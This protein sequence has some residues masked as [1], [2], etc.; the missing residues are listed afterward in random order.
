[1][2][3]VRVF[4]TIQISIHALRE[5]SDWKA[6]DPSQMGA[7]SIHALRE[8]SDKSS[9]PRTFFIWRFQSTLSVRRATGNG[10]FAPN[11][12]EIS[13]HALRE[14]SDIFRPVGWRRI[15]ISIHALREESDRAT[16]WTRRSVSH[17]NPRSP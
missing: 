1:M 15:F 9:S 13:I 11:L 8:E 10:V 3:L 6:K 17:F 5:E 4:G 16:C 14:E 7:I 2:P 12:Y